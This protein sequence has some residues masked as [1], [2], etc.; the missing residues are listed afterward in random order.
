VVIQQPWVVFVPDSCWLDI[1]LLLWK[2]QRCLRGT[3][4]VDKAKDGRRPWCEGYSRS[5]SIA[6]SGGAPENEGN[7]KLTRAERIRG[8]VSI[9]LINFYLRQC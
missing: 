5:V 6:V 1:Q 9:S 8:E 3:H 4:E 2:S 7:S